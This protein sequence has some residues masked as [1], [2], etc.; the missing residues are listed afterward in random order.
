M[1]APLAPRGAAVSPLHESCFQKQLLAPTRGR[2]PGPPMG[3]G[4]WLP[5]PGARRSARF[6][7]RSYPNCPPTPRRAAD[8]RAVFFLT[9]LGIFS[10]VDGVRETTQSRQI[11]TASILEVSPLPL[12][13][14]LPEI[15]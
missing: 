2:S 11:N 6:W 14:A 7:V 10:D 3:W 15:V 12:D 1:F 13:P 5:S 8:R 4:A 9:T